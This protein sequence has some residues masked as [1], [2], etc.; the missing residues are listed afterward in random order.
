VCAYIENERETSSGIKTKLEA[1]CRAGARGG[2]PMRHLGARAGPLGTFSG[3][4]THKH[5][6][7]EMTWKAHIFRVCLFSRG[8]SGVRASGVGGSAATEPTRVIF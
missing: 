7:P 4:P 3:I 1:T 5:P 6:F 8:G 2:N